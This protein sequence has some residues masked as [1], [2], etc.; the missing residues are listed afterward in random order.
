[1][2][3]AKIPDLVDCVRELGHDLAVP[4]LVFE[5]IR[6]PRALKS[7]ED[8]A[9]RGKIVVLEE[10]DPETV[11]RMR[12]RF[13]SLG[14]GECDAILACREGAYCILDDRRARKS[15]SEMGVK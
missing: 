6:S 5:E 11:E 9:E 15:A 10:A 14:S 3:D 4:A 13:P 12:R 7:V 1:M 8:L 2:F